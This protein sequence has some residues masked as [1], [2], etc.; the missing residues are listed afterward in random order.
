MVKLEDKKFLAEWMG[1]EK[2][3][4]TGDT[5]LRYIF[6]NNPNALYVEDEFNP[7]TDHKDFA[8]VWNK[9]TMEQQQI[10]IKLSVGEPLNVATHCWWTTKLLMHPEQ[11]MDKVLELL[12][13]GE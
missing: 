6:P 4:S 10:V 2:K 3:I 9:M 11:V 7:D 5:L 12:K 8:E 13:G 1:A